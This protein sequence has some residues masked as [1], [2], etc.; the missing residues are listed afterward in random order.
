M[1]DIYEKLV[2]LGDDPAAVAA[3]AQAPPADPYEQALLAAS[4]KAPQFPVTQGEW[5]GPP[6][7]PSGFWSTLGHGAYGAVKGPLAGVLGFPGNMLQG[8][9]WTRYERPLQELPPG[10]E[11]PPALG[12]RRPVTRYINP[13]PRSETIEKGVDWLA[14]QTGLYT[15]P[16]PGT[17]A[18]T[19]ERMATT[20]GEVVAPSRVIPGMSVGKLQDVWVGIQALVGEEATRMLSEGATPEDLERNGKIGAGVAPMLW[21]LL[22]GLTSIGLRRSG[23]T[24]LPKQVELPAAET[25]LKQAT[26][27][28]EETTE[29]Y[30]ARLAAMQERNRLQQT[31]EEERA[32]PLPAARG[33]EQARLTAAEAQAGQQTAQTEKQMNLATQ[34]SEE[35]ARLAQGEVRTPAQLEAAAAEPLKPVV[36]ALNPTPGVREPGAQIQQAV[37][38]KAD[39]AATTRAL[40]QTQRTEKL[41][42]DIG[43]KLEDAAFIDLSKQ[44]LRPKFLQQRK[45]VGQ[46]F[47]QI[48]NELGTQRVFDLTSTRTGLRRLERE[49]RASGQGIDPQ[50]AKWAEL[51]LSKAQLASLEGTTGLD[52]MQKALGMVPAEKLSFAAARD[53]ENSLNAAGSGAPVGSLRQA[54]PRFLARAI[55]DDMTTFFRTDMG[56]GVGPAMSLAKQQYTEFLT[57]WNNG[58]MRHLVDP[59][60]GYQADNFLNFLTNTQRSQIPQL[61]AVMQQAAPETQA[62]ISAHVAGDMARKATDTVTG[63]VN[64]KQLKAQVQ[65]LQKSGVFQ[66]VFDET[67]QKQILDAVQDMTAK[68]PSILPQFRKAIEGKA[69]EDVVKFVFE[70]GKITRTENYLSI[71]PKENVTLAR[72]AWAR[73]FLQDYESGGASAVQKQLTQL[74]KEDDG[75]SQ[76]A[77]LFPEQEFP[78][79]VDKFKSAHA[80][81]RTAP[82]RAQATSERAARLQEGVGETKKIAG[83]AVEMT[84]EAGARMVAEAQTRFDAATRT[85]TEAEDR[86]KTMRASGAAQETREKAEGALAVKRARDEQKAAQKAVAEV[87]A[88]VEK[89]QPNAARRI[90]KYAIGGGGSGL[91]AF[92]YGMTHTTPLAPYMLAS[93]VTLGAITAM[94]ASSMAMARFARTQAGQRLMRDGLKQRYGDGAARWVNQVFVQTPEPKEGDP[95][96]ATTP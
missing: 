40:E 45:V 49:A 92:L 39:T 86:L 71:A 13:L 23:R 69:P 94:E 5:Q 60:A 74:L 32:L 93:G 59:R 76:L 10:V 8:M 31:V 16:I 1:A 18:A 79:M 75:V 95:V 36:E 21:A 41:V 19:A 91:F 15:P 42:S 61:R 29:E 46:T 7:P 26:T 53:I 2:G 20:F 9:P 44:D 89:Q 38:E 17:S 70:P 48:E 57:T 56:T 24:H 11:G 81:L 43:P 64:P 55:G 34:M 25:K 72:Q 54:P 6:V 33:A 78:G 28:L 14:K 50:Y 52:R 63:Q 47:D 30:A 88:K 73:Q 3:P 80:E 12:R 67:Q 90:A 83:Q 87:E 96:D 35:Q 65:R 37:I 62:A 58:I 4:E 22:H 85:L 84:E 77:L 82:Q 51:G 27:G 68:D 66:E